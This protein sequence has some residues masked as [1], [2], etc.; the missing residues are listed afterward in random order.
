MEHLPCHQA[1]SAVKC[2]IGADPARLHLVLRSTVAE[3]YTREEAD[4]PKRKQQTCSP[5]S[6][7]HREPARGADNFEVDPDQFRGRGRYP[8]D[9]WF[10]STI[11]ELIERC[12]LG[13][14]KIAD[15]SAPAVHYHG[16]ATSSCSPNF[17]M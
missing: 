13:V 4:N 5:P 17:T 10:Y 9:A 6:V 2:H 11:H 8:T 1:L 3:G 16:R 14:V 15:V 7:R 12:V